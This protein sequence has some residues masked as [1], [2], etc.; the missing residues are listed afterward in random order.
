MEGGVTD[1]GV[2]RWVDGSTARWKE[3][4]ISRQRERCVVGGLGTVWEQWE[5][6][7]ACI[8]IPALPPTNGVILSK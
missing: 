2:G 4:C 3:G 6:P 5:L 7:C 1:D 8:G